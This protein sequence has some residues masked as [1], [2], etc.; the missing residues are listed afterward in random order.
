[1]KQYALTKLLKIFTF[2]RNLLVLMNTLRN[3]STF[4]LVLVTL[5]LSGCEYFTAK[6]VAQM[7]T[8]QPQICGDLNP[9]SWCRAEKAEIIKFRFEHQ[10][11]EP[12][13]DKYNLMM[14][15]EDYQVCI[16]KAAQI[17]HIKLRE[18]ETGR[19]KGLL[20]AQNELKRLSNET[21]YSENPYLA[22]YQWSRHGHED[23]LK[24]FLYAAERGEL[25]SAALNV[26]HASYLVKRDTAKAINALYTA[27][28]LYNEDEDI[29]PEVF[30]SLF[31]LHNERENLSEAV[32]WGLVGS[33]FDNSTMDKKELLALAEESG[34]SLEEVTSRASALYSRIE[35][36]EFVFNQ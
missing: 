10:D 9:D 22:Y 18:K 34:L 15:F 3:F 19:M 33:E 7:C 1:M 25:H 21:R 29:D 20:T 11:G 30:N 5:T 23:S 12:E 28:S 8:E 32:V 35:S 24:A 27:L 17:R 2:C 36:R 16:A 13:E 14:Y 6:T 4:I 31:T 26:A